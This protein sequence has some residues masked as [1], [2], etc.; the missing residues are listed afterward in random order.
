MPE[1]RRAVLYPHRK[2][3]LFRAA[4][5][6]VSPAGVAGGKIRDNLET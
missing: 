2:R 3:K 5:A 4:G 1:M 6:R